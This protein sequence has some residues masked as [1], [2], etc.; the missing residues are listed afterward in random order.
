MPPPPYL[1]CPHERGPARIG[2]E[3]DADTG[4]CR[5]GTREFPCTGAYHYIPVAYVLYMM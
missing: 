1:C 3:G 4:A 2:Q 5:P